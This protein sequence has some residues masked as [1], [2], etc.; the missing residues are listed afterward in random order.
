MGLAAVFEQYGIPL[1]QIEW[2]NY[3]TVDRAALAEK[4][5]RSDVLYFCG[6]EP[7]LLYQRLELL[8]LMEPLRCFDG[9]VMGDSA[10]AVIQLERYRQQKGLGYLQG[11]DLEVHFT[12][13]EAQKETIQRVLHAHGRPVYALYPNG[14]LVVENG[15]IHSIGEVVC[16]LPE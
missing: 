14:A 7:E 5:A 1:S 3:Y 15:W 2:V 13:E 9:I 12:G 8:K 4:I 10:G 11:F 6:G 16:V